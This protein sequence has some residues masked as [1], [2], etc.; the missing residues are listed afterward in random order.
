M[1][2][3]LALKAS[4]TYVD[5]QLAAA[6]EQLLVERCGTLAV[7][8]YDMA[9]F[10]PTVMILADGGTANRT[11][12]ARLFAKFGT[13]YGVGDG[14]TTFGLPEWRGEFVRALDLGR[15]IDVGRAHGSHQAQSIQS[16]SHTLPVNDDSSTGNGYVEDAQGS[17]TP[18]TASTGS[19]GDTETRPRNV[20]LPHAIWR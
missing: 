19:T 11:D 7:L 6:R 10:D 15:G 20:A 12:D 14:A 3:Q 9:F 1:I 2:A 17:G 18:R 4:L 5:D 16:H 13:T 8:G